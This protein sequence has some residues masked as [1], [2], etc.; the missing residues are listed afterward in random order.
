MIYSLLDD[1]VIINLLEQH[2][3]YR[4]GRGPEIDNYLRKIKNGLL[5]YPYSAP[6]SQEN[7]DCIENWISGSQVDFTL[8][9]LKALLTSM[10]NGIVRESHIIQEVYVEPLGI[11]IQAECAFYFLHIRMDHFAIKC[12]SDL[13]LEAEIP[14][15]QRTQNPNKQ[16]ISEARDLVEDLF[17]QI[18]VTIEFMKECDPKGDWSEVRKDLI[19]R[20]D[21]KVLQ[22]LHELAFASGRCADNAFASSFTDKADFIKWMKDTKNLTTFPEVIDDS[23]QKALSFD[24]PSKIAVMGTI[25][26]T[27][28][29]NQK[30]AR[31]SS[32]Q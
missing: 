6:L 30:L 22:P 16:H 19:K 28:I 5:S 17:K 31:S 11:P 10:C 4:N 15:T 2:Q 29:L 27:Y 23:F 12:R 13:W 26:N 9:Q 1:A 7:K 32:A 24:D 20:A 8:Q 21:S 25:L 18:S 3:P 14:L